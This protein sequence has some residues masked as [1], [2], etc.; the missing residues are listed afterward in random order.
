[1][2]ILKG[3][4]NLARIM[5]PDLKNPDGSYVFL[6]KATHDQI[7]GF[8]DHP[9]C[10]GNPIVIMPD[11]HYGKGSCVGFTMPLGDYVIPNMVGVDIGCGIYSFRLGRIYVDNRILESL[12]K[13]I[14]ETI[15]SGF[16]VHSG[17]TMKQLEKD[18]SRFDA[19]IMEDFWEVAE[20]I[21]NEGARTRFHES[22]GT[23]GGG[24]H[25]VELGVD[26]E[27]NYWITVH[28]GSRSFGL[29]VANFYQ[30]LARQQMNKFFVDPKEYKDSEFLPSGMGMETYLDDMYV[31]QRYAHVN[32]MMMLQKIVE[33]WFHTNL[34]EDNLWA[35]VHNYI[36]PDDGVIRKGA[37]S[38]HDGEKV[39]IPFN[40]EDGLILG[41]GKGNPLWNN[42]GPHG[43]GRVLSRNKAKEVLSL[44]DAK[45]GMNKAGVFTTSLSKETLDEAKGAYKPK[46]LI[47]E[48]IRDTVD[49]ETFVKPVYNFKAK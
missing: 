11:C 33:G 44:E 12:D 4:Y 3:K 9:A 22:F 48:M 37:I 30:N 45:S 8:L 27:Q 38:A 47:L 41:Y 17:R 19:L 35:T 1:M 16:S 34:D 6:D 49:V 39:V 24:N 20:T 32:R 23:L 40:M 21:R 31:A 25:F 26:E 36:D 46:E 29:H 28:S 14:R 2:I 18:A 5:L 42:S 13:Y 15:P 7:R 10:Q 43:A